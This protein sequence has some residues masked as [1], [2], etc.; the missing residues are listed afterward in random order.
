MQTRGLARWLRAR[1]RP[2]DI[3]LYSEQ[4]RIGQEINERFNAARARLKK[5]YASAL[6]PQQKRQHKEEILAHTGQE[7]LAIEQRSH[8]HSEYDRWISSGLNNAH[9]AAVGT[10][11]DCVDGFEELLHQ[12]HGDPPQFYAAVRRIARDPAARRSLCHADATTT[13]AK[14][15]GSSSLPRLID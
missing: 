1:G 11:F 7:V 15:A 2:G 3:Q 8:L 14:S 13:A 6:S 5:L 12:Q 10:Y 4:R 9:L